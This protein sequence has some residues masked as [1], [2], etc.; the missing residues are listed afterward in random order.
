MNPLRFRKYPS[1]NTTPRIPFSRFCSTEEVLH[2]L[3]QGVGNS[4]LSLLAPGIEH[5][6][7]LDFALS[8]TNSVSARPHGKYYGQR[9]EQDRPITFT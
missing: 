7:S 9:N 3:Q 5:R 1:P 8:F 4:E 2:A 6:Q